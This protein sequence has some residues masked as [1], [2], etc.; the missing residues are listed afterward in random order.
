MYIALQSQ[1]VRAIPLKK[2]E[3]AKAGSMGYEI[4]RL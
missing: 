3:N 4:G 1:I 2:Y